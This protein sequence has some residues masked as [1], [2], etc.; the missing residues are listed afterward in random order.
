MKINFRQKYCN[1]IEIQ[2]VRKI[3]HIIYMSLNLNHNLQ[4]P[5]L[6]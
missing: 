6:D 1:A 3:K 4:P 2:N 5:A